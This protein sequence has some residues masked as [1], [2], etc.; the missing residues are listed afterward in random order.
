[1]DHVEYIHTAGMDEREVE[2]RLSAGETGVLALAEESKA[3]AIPLAFHY[4]GERIVFRLGT[5]DDARKMAYVDATDTASFVHH[6]YD[7]P[8]SSWSIVVEG[9]LE[10]D[11][12][13]YDEAEINA[14]FPALRV[15]DEAIDDL[16]VELVAMRMER[17]TGRASLR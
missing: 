2:R 9:P 7:A 11:A 1:M 16:D 5:G 6:G 15:F 4:D 12:V 17:V 14:R 10:R 13:D 3:Y 8:D